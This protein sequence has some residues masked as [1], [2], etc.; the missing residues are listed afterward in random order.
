MPF[1][2]EN[3]L[4]VGAKVVDTRVKGMNNLEVNGGDAGIEKGYGP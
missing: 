3:E 1:E 2:R 4:Q